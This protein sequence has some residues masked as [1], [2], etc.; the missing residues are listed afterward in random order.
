MRQRQHLRAQELHLA[1]LLAI[2]RARNAFM[3]WIGLCRA[4]AHC[5]LMLLT[6]ALYG[7]ADHADYKRDRRATANA[8][9]HRVL[10]GLRMRSFCAWAGYAK[11]S[12]LGRQHISQS[13]PFAQAS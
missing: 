11:V 3:L 5:R 9:Q 2:S 12:A 6:R 1:H 7:W 8:A 13:W 4:T 10:H